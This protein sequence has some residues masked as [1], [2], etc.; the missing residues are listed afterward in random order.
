MV[1]TMHYSGVAVLEAHGDEQV[2]REAASG[3][4][5][6]TL[7]FSESASRSHFWAPASSAESRNGDIKL[8]A[9]KSWVT[10]ASHATAYV[11]SSRPLAAEGL[12]T[13]W[14][15]PASARG[16][17]VQGPF[18]GLGLRGNDSSP[19]AAAAVTVPRTAMLGADGQGFDIMMSVVMP[20]FAILSAACSNGL[21]EGALRRT[22]EHSTRTRHSDTGATLADLPTIRSYL[23]R[24]RMKAD[25][26]SALLTDTLAAL[27]EGRPEATLRVLEC[28]A[29][30][31]EAANEV[32]DIAMRICGGAAFR[33][34]VAV[35][36]FFRDARASSVMAPTPDFLYDLI[37]KL[38]CGMPLF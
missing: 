22:I 10:A 35:E 21:M 8:N 3:A 12:S 14:L 16:L 23:A 25:Q 20:V 6:S 4:H 33:K 11:W 34:D 26:S 38:V 30:A 5:L 17:T 29:A 18:D 15:V 36:R 2:R 28:K 31:A 7:A 27:S 37:G 13:L 32:L 24:M 19:V 9:A 1:L